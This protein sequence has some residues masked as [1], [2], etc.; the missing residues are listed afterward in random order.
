MLAGQHPH[1][2]APGSEHRSY[3][4]SVLTLQTSRKR[5]KRYKGENPQ[6]RTFV[7]FV[8][9]VS[10]STLMA[11]ALLLLL[12]LIVFPAA[13]CAQTVEAVGIRAQGMGGAFT[14]VADDASATWWNPAGLAAGAYFNLIL[15][16]TNQEEPSSSAAVPGWRATSRGFAVAYPALGLSYYRLRISEIQPSGSTAAGAPG[17]QDPGTEKVRLRATTWNQFGATV[18]QSLGAHVVVASTVKLVRAGSAVDVQDR[19]AASRDSADDLSP[20]S[21]THAGL[22]VGAMAKFGHLTLGVSVRNATEPSFGSGDNRFTLDRQARAGIALTALTA[23]IGQLT[24]D[25]DADIT[26]TT[27]VFGGERRFGAGAELWTMSRRLGLR[28]GVAGWFPGEVRLAPSGGVSVAVRQ[29]IYVDA[30]VTGRGGEEVRV[31]W[32]S[33]LRVTF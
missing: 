22:D 6:G 17:R 3:K 5:Y 28:G 1:C 26:H 12:L 30:Q 14:A 27:T 25:A 21:E 24:I 10:F 16:L 7:S 18:G 20:P 11:F 23:A 15:E 33:A 2:E 32:G 31:G 4:L 9:F 19:T 29:G 8:P 13:L